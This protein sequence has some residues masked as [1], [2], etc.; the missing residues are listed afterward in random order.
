[1]VKR[2]LMCAVVTVCVAGLS[3]AG[4][5]DNQNKKNSSQS[6][7]TQSSANQSGSSQNSSSQNSASQN[8]SAKNGSSWTGW[9]TDSDCGA[10][11]ASA[12]H[13]D[14]AKK[15]VADKGAKYVLYNTSD[16]K[17]YNLDDQS[18]AAEHVAHLVKVHGT[19]DGDTIHVQSITASA[20][21]QKSAS[22]NDKSGS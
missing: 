16:K 6:S 2:I 21:K 9:I 14:C 22:S 1:M 15:C 8:N 17:V 5:Q 7:S 19:V 12:N 13:A 4:Q 3:F 10:K 20:S 18:A 11:G